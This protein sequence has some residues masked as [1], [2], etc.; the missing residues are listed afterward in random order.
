MYFM[1]FM[2]LWSFFSFRLY[3]LSFLYFRVAITYNFQISVFWFS[4]AVTIAFLLELSLF[5][6]SYR[7]NSQLIRASGARLEFCSRIISITL[8]VIGHNFGFLLSVCNYS[9]Q[10][11]IRLCFKMVGASRCCAV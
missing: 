7:G 1:Y 5:F 9:N 8:R 4:R 10:P 6:Q 2:N 11:D 3:L